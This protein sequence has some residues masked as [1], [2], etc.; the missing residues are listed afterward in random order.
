MTVAVPPV[1]NAG[2]EA[3]L[4]GQRHEW[5]L[6]VLLLAPSLL[7]FGVFAFYPLVQTVVLA[8]HRSD[9]FGGLGRYV[10]VEALTD[11]LGS[12]DFRHSLWVT[13]KFAVLTVPT[14]LALGTGLAVLAHRS[15]RGIG[16][17]RT[18]FSSTIAT[19]VAVASLMWLMLLNPSLG[20][21][22]QLLRELG[23]DPVVFFQDETWA[24]LSVSMATIW[25]HLGFTFIVVSAGLTLVPDELLEAARLDGAG[26]WI[27]FRRVILP[28]LSPSLLLASVVLMINAFQSFGQI[29]LLTQGGPI[30][31]T[32]V[33][34]YAVFQDVSSD[35]STAAAQALVLFVIVLVLTLV[36]LFFLGRRVTYGS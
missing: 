19:S 30:D 8:L 36:Q 23:R 4:P 13:V 11:V 1:S 22:N 32:K 9:P 15:L 17:F 21:V 33:L 34:V 20:L 26:P 14:G 27:R 28:L 12:D 2:D 35:P 25:Q 18:I 6:A 29:D 3:P 24:L 16:I 5:R 31:S 7:I 10:G